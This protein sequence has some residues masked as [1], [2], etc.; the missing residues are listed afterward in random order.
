MTTTTQ[1]QFEDY[2]KQ[3]YRTFNAFNVYNTLDEDDYYSLGMEVFLKSIESYDPEM[4]LKF[5][6][7]YT[8]KLRSYFTAKSKSE[9][10]QHKLRSELSEGQ[11]NAIAVSYD[12]SDIIIDDIIHRACLTKKEGLMLQ[13]FRDGYTDS[14]TA[15]RWDITR[16]RAFQL[17][18]KLIRRLKMVSRYRDLMFTRRNLNDAT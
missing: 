6:V 12:N 14:E 8:W 9:N 10:E 16:Q 5:G 2:E 15:K 13:E 4:G 3:F 7:H 1:P 17:R 11:W 18:Q